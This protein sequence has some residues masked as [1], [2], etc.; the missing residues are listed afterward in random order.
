MPFN[1]GNLRLYKE[2]L[3]VIRNEQN[4]AVKHREKA[5]IEKHISD[6]EKARML[7]DSMV[8]NVLSV[9]KASTTTSN[10]SDGKKDRKSD[11]NI[12]QIKTKGKP[13]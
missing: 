1:L 4:V 10:I 12:A 6:I 5:I 8:Q 13:I 7:F 9:N 11:I 2:D 3:N